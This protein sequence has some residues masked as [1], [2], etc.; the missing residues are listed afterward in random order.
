MHLFLGWRAMED[1]I[2]SIAYTFERVL[3]GDSRARHT[4]L[5]ACSD[6]HPL[7]LIEIDVGNRER[8][9]KKGM[10]LKIAELEEIPNSVTKLELIG[11]TTSPT[12]L[13]QLIQNAQTY[14]QE[15]PNYHVLL[16]NCRTFVESLID[17][18][19]EFRNSIPRK[20]GSILEYYHSQ[21]KHEH[22]GALVKSK[23]LLKDVRDV[24]RH[25]RQYKYTSKLVLNIELPTLDVDINTDIIEV[26]L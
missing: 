15:H 23:Q 22:P 9:I 4:F 5:I 18:I 21:A 2:G 1:R 8:G 12:A 6:E 13:Q 20:K 25:N 24:H 11:E 26:R 7:T 14:V 19:P 16:N 3:W 17:E 10:K